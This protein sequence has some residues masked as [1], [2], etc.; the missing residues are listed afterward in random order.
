MTEQT[1]QV[2]E[3]MSVE[4]VRRKGKLFNSDKIYMRES[5]AR[6]RGVFARQP[7]K[8]GETIEVCPVIVVPDD[9]WEIID[10]TVLTNY[11]IVFGEKDVGLF[12]L[13]SHAE[14]SSLPRWSAVNLFAFICF[15]LLPFS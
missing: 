12:Y 2:P 3:G 5:S 8:A 9:Q 7:I 6:G 4:V 15:F 13:P 1:E 10:T 14:T 11:Y